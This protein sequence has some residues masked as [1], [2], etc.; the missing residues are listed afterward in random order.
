MSSKPEDS[1]RK[2]GVVTTYNC[3]KGFGF[4]A[5][6][7]E[8]DY[9]LHVS[10]IESQRTPRIGEPV[11]FKSGPATRG[12]RGEALEVKFINLTGGADG[13]VITDNTTR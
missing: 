1:E 13:N 7:G 9:F 10:Q 2:S 4:I 8:S 12:K 5:V 3:L 11:T 6:V